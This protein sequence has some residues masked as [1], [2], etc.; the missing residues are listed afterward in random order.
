VD[1]SNKDKIWALLSRS[2]SGEASEA[3]LQELNLLLQNSDNYALATS[4]VTEYWHMPEE[5]D[6]DFL[7]ATYHLH[8]NRLK[9]KGH[10]VETVAETPGSFEIEAPSKGVN[11]K[12]LVAGTILV[13]IGIF[14]TILVPFKNNSN[15]ATVT[16]NEVNIQKGTRT[17]LTLPDGSLV[18]LNSDSKLVY[19]AESFAAGVREVNL[20]GEGYFD[21]VKNPQRPFIIHTSKINIKVL[22]TAF[23]VKAYPEDKQTETSLIHGKIE[24]TIN[25]RPGEKIVMSPNQKLVVNNYEV[26]ITKSANE[27]VNST[28]S[29]NSA[30][31]AVFVDRLKYNTIDSTLEETQWVNNMLVF[32][33][34]PFTEV[35]AMMERWYNVKIEIEDTRLNEMNITGKFKNETVTEALNALQ[36]SFMFKYKKDEDGRITI[37]R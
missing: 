2:L 31:K 28:T 13:A 24:V 25:D 12:I 5:P 36:F 4:L 35:T 26:P 18:W 6:T 9:A 3:E 11:K 29:S 7:E 23:N 21:V 16:A 20:T 8:L 19:S 10:T 32:S 17:K 37:Y 34:K 33:D 1:A 22:G 15:A 27:K 14:L 30:P